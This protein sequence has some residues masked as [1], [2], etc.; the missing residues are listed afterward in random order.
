MDINIKIRVQSALLTATLLVHRNWFPSSL[1]GDGWDGNGFQ[2]EK[3]GHFFQVP[4]RFIGKWLKADHSL[5]LRGEMISY[6]TP[7]ALRAIS[8]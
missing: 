1:V 4:R 3:L 7:G 8:C 6:F 2:L 5:F